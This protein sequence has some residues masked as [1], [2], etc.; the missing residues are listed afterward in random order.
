MIRKEQDGIQWL[1]FEL[2]VPY[3]EMVHGVFLRHG[4]C[5]NEP[6]D[7]LNISYQSGDSYEDV[8]KNRQMVADCL[9][10][11]S[12]LLP[13]LEHGKQVVE[14]ETAS[15]DRPV[16]DGVM[17]K[18]PELGLMI[19]HADCQAAIFYDPENKALANVHAGWRGNVQD[20][21][22]ETVKQMEEKFGS[23]PENLLVGISPS[24]CPEYSEF[25]H[26]RTKLPE[27]F[28]PYQVKPNHF[29]LWEV[30]RWQLESAGVLSH[31][32]EIAKI[33][34]YSNPK[35][36]YSYRRDKITGRHGTLAYVK[37]SP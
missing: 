27:S 23:H 26:Y 19:T 17:T 10:C 1:E 34:T 29:D 11:R 13:I 28:L 5:S 30:S 3:D 2:F 6:F 14:I 9:G 12:F 18:E 16:A 20:I 37:E 24:L 31:H 35:D 25:I 7:S 4:G 15:C 36:F 22:G 8:H 33:S 32:I 21:Y